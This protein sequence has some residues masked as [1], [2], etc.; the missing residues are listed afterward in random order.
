MISRLLLGALDAWQLLPH[1]LLLHLTFDRSD[2]CQDLTRQEAAEWHRGR[3][4][5]AGLS[6]PYDISILLRSTSTT[7][8]IVSWQNHGVCI[9]RGRRRKKC[10]CMT[11]LS[12]LKRAAVTLAAAATATMGKRHSQMLLNLTTLNTWTPRLSGSQQDP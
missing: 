6:M 12:G 8:P 5:L 3:A 1:A 11:D 10:K 9:S 7:L 2:Q 4:E